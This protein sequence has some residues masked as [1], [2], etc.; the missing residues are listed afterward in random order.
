L[1]K[2]NAMK[3][4]SVI[5]LAILTTAS[6]TVYAA[7]AAQLDFSIPPPDGA[8][9]PDQTPPLLMPNSAPA[10]TVVKTITTTTTIT[11]APAAPAGPGTP[12][13]TH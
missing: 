1:Q 12:T 7:T 9:T 3:V 13:P 8:L 4:L 11:P 6:L 10:A 5:L 2:G